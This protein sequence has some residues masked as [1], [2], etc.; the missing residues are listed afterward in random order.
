MPG[1]GAGLIECDTAGW[2]SLF[3][4]DTSSIRRAAIRAEGERIVEYIAEHPEAAA[5]LDDYGT[6][7]STPS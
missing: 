1:V 7:L 2:Y 5:E 3:M 6:P 4:G